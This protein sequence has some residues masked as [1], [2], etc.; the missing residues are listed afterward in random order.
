MNSR[1]GFFLAGRDTSTPFSWSSLEG[2]TVIVDHFFQP[3][4]LF[5]TALR[6]RGVDE[7][8]VR[9][10]D[11]GDVSRMEAAFRAGEGDFLHA[12]GP[13]PQQLEREQLARVVASIGEAAGPLAFS[14]LC[15]RP[16]WLATD[17]ARAFHRVYRAARAE[18][19]AAPVADVVRRISPFLPGVSAEALAATVDGYQRLGTWAGDDT[20]TVPL[21][22]RTVDIFL[23]VGHI[24]SRPAFEDVAAAAPVA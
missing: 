9:M 3:L 17:V 21:F 1:D 5:R 18:A 15:A 4:A 10:V 16:E 24:S 7:T 20:F 12:Q 13:V 14:S 6:A 11:A 8:K 22:E 23:A 19:H 2:R